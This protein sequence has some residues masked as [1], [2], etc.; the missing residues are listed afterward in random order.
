MAPSLSLVAG[1]FVLY[2][3]ARVVDQ[4]GRGLLFLPSMFL[5]S[6]YGEAAI[7]GALITTIVVGALLAVYEV[8]RDQG[9]RK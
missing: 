5:L 1:A 9:G 7:P 3:V 6:S 8:G 2:L 4:R